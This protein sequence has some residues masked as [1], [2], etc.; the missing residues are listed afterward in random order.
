MRKVVLK[1]DEKRKYEVIKRLVETDGNRTRAAVYLGCSRSS[2]YRMMN[3]YRTRGKEFFVHGNAG[4]KPAHARS[5]EEREMIVSLYSSKYRDANYTFFSELLREVEGINA[6][7]GLV[8][9]ILMGEGILSP[10]ATKRTRRELAKE[11]RTTLGKSGRKKERREI[12]CRIVAVEDAHAHRP[13]CAYFGELIQMD[14]SIHPWFGERK[15]SLHVA[16]DDATGIIVGAFFDKEETLHGY[17]S[18]LRKILMGYG[19]PYRL[20]TDR[21]TVFEYRSSADR[22]VENDTFTQFSYALKQLGIDI[23]TSSVPQTKGRVE[24]AFGTLQRRLPILLRMADVVSIEQA[25]AFLNRYIEEYNARFALNPDN[26][27]SI[28][29]KQPAKRKIDLILAVLTPRVI[30]AGHAVKFRGVLYMPTSSNGNPIHFRKGSRGLVIE[31]FD[32]GLF[33][34]LHDKVYALDAIPEREEKS[35][36]IDGVPRV[37]AKR[38][39]YVPSMNH[40][41][42][43]TSF[44][45][46]VRRQAHTNADDNDPQ[47]A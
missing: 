44:D 13:R 43:L 32:G 2:V 47:G 14:A 37:R 41:W 18:V 29:E 3:G 25:N 28:F 45:S 36:E 19:I 23:R 15:T 27:P 22:R 12:E 39:R 20:L 30:D 38:K 1:M 10:L 40:P 7:P 46:H 8:R 33:F 5:K 35:P 17:Y 26:I 21:R 11:L 24:R 4:R 9:R 6:S 16:V 31:A 34:S 42:R